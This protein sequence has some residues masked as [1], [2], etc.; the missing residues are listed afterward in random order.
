M[1]IDLSRETI[2]AKGAVRDATLQ[3][4]PRRCHAG[5]FMEFGPTALNARTIGFGDDFE[6][7]LQIG[8][9]YRSGRAV[10]LER[11]PIEVLSFLIEHQG[12]L[13]TR[14]AIVDRVW[15][16]GVFL[17]TD[18]GIN[19]AIR[20]LRLA[21]HDNPE[22]PAFIQTI[23]GKG[24]RFIAPIQVAIQERADAVED[25]PAV[26]AAEPPAR[27]VRP[28]MAFL[29]A[30]VVL[31]VALA[32]YL[33]ARGRRAP[34]APA[35]VML[36]VVPFD[37]LTGDP[38]EEYFSDGL[39]EEMITR[40]GQLDPKRLGVIGR[41]S[42]MHYKRT[43]TPIAQI[44]RELGVQYVLEG[45]VRRSTGT[46][47]ITAQLIQA[48]DGTNVWADEYDRGPQDV[49]LVQDDIADRIARDTAGKLGEAA[50]PARTADARGGL[51]PDE[52]A[53][54]EL[55]LK[56]L[57]FFNKREVPAFEQA[58]AEFERAIAKDP[59]YARAHAGLA[60]SL[61]LLTAYNLTP[62]DAVVERA[63]AAARRAIAIDDRL[64]EAHT[65]LALVVQNYDWNW[66]AAEQEFRRAIELNPNYAT[67]HHWY[68]EHLT[69]RGRF[70]EALDQI[71]RAR[72][73]DPLSLII[74]ADRA[75]ILYYA[76]RYDPA[77]AEFRAV[78]DLEPTFPRA[79]LIASA[80]VE[81][82][83]L[84]EALQTIEQQRKTESPVSYW[85]S[86]AYVYG[87]AG[88]AAEARR[89]LDALNKIARTEPT[90][91]AVFMWA[92]AAIGD[93][94]AAFS[95]LDRAYAQ[96]SNAMTGLKVGPG[97]DRLR[98]DPRFERVLRRIGLADHVGAN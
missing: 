68:A 15:G 52:Y 10:R 25:A 71:E 55:Y 41:T 62:Q 3:Y 37:N 17:D 26:S 2:E 38:N 83:R 81:E 66:P 86:L 13:V 56:G 35:R 30:G 47:R 45:S 16:K 70:A 88:R 32:G 40:L 28:W 94:D 14:E 12:E 97:Y 18:N 39:T 51:S 58:I 29:A 1:L 43:S 96:H 75:A 48:R 4:N 50:P 72:Q 89:A 69:W 65:A 74:A 20:K 64:P 46:L 59:K 61:M 33:F 6:L 79:Q 80:Y 36:A 95:W 57:Y 63:R 19:S 82:G 7:D 92:Y 27:S 31:C 78:L 9:L 76:R 90:D 87:R 22:S 21:L 91:P 5:G 60:E 44:A 54:Y 34:S 23:T 98:D 77:I 42:V 24:Y 11:I 67:A 53:A 85:S 73:L 84:N 49:L 8:K 93:K